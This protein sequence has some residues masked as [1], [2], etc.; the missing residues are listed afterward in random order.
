MSLEVLVVKREKEDLTAR[1]LEV[2]A[3]VAV[4]KS[5]KQIA[6]E[7]VISD[8]TVESH[9]KNIFGKWYVFSRTEASYYAYRLGIAV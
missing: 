5:N 4:G 7:L 6:Q 3:L 9:L 2:L 1:E 8:K